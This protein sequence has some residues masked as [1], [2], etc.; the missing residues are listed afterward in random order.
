MIVGGDFNCVLAKTDV[1][2]HF[3]YSLTVNELVQ[4]F[5][6]VDMWATIPERG[7]YTYYTWQGTSR[8]NRIYVSRN[9]SGRKCGT[10]AIMTAFPDH[11]AVVLR[12]VLNVTAVC[13]DRYYWKINAALLRETPFLETLRQRWAG[14]ARQQ[15]HYP[16]VV[17]WWERV[18]KKQLRHLF[19]CEGTERR[20]DDTALEHFYHACLCDLLQTPRPGGRDD[21]CEPDKGKICKTLWR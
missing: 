2:G 1:T 15:K 12:I 7:I 10:E 11:L 14:W 4:G 20:R 8:L 19:T 6:L 17:M 18:A 16:N 5:D 13:R 21:S 3:N 9:L